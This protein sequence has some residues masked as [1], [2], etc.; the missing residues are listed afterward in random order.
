MKVIYA[1]DVVLLGLVIYMYYPVPS[2]SPR[3]KSWQSKGMFFNYKEFKI[4]NIDEVGQGGNDDVLIC[5]HGFPTSSYD[6]IKVHDSILKLFGRVIFLDFLGYGFSDK[7]RHHKYSILEQAD[8]VEALLAFNSI[9]QFHI[10]AHDIGNTVGLELLARQHKRN[11]MKIMSFTMM[12]GGIFPETNH[13]RPIQRILLL[14]FLGSLISKIGFFHLFRFTFGEV[15]GKNK[16]TEDDFKDFWSLMEQQHG[17]GISNRL[18]QF[19]P[20]RTIYKHRWV[21]ALKKAT[22]PVL[23]IYGP[24]DPINTKPFIEHYKKLV[25]QHQFHLLGNQVGHYPQWEDPENVIR[26][27]KQFLKDILL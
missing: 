6:W 23:F 10:L 22:L 20:E 15:F 19:I 8:I 12:N 14:P 5:L 4:F 24:A 2:L 25:P 7:P 21:G 17:T 26:A 16:P 9:N 1:V 3:V 27:Y 11:S 18:L 13:P